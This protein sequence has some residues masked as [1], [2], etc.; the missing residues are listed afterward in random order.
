MTGPFPSAREKRVG[1]D[2]VHDEV[3][4]ELVKEAEVICGVTALLTRTVEE[5][6]EQIRCTSPGRL[7]ETAPGVLGMR[8][9][10]HV[11]AAPWPWVG[12]GWGEI[13]PEGHGV[14]PARAEPSRAAGLRGDF[15]SRHGGGG[16]GRPG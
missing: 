5:V 16:S 6:S 8:S 13:H 3:E 12:T 14:F 15:R 4:Q 1:I 2:L 11:T 10:A 9:Q 7:E